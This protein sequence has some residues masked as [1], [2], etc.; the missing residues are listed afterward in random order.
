MVSSKRGRRLRP[1]CASD[2]ILKPRSLQVLGSF[3][4]LEDVPLPS[5]RYEFMVDPK[6]MSHA[7]VGFLFPKISTDLP[8]RHG[9]RSLASRVKLLLA[10][11]R[12]AHLVDTMA[13]HCP[14]L[15]GEGEG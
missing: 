15:N 9:T 8:Q 12:P 6:G 10:G 4:S 13:V 1:I 3:D 2:Q 11:S 14:L 7:P 5:G